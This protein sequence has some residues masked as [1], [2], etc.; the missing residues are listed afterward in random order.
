MSIN[1]WC[2]K[3]SDI[4]LSCFGLDIQDKLTDESYFIFYNQRQS[5][6]KALIIE[7]LSLNSISYYV[8]LGILA[9]KINNLSFILSIDDDKIF[10]QLNS[11]ELTIKNSQDNILAC[12]KFSGSDFI[13]NKIIK[14]FDIYYYKD[15]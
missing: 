11:S 7:N 5:P 12:Y 6:E 4:D 9:N 13:E 1:L 8:N 2:N 10:S 3:I 15:Q 14:L